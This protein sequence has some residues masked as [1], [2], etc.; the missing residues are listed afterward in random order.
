MFTLV[1]KKSARNHIFARMRFRPEISGPQLFIHKQTRMKRAN[2]NNNS[3][4]RQR[5]TKGFA[6]KSAPVYI[7]AP[8]LPSGEMKYFDTYKTTTALGVVTTTWPAGA[9]VD[10]TTTV[11]LGAAAVATPLSLFVPTVGSALN[12]R[13]GR[14]VLVRKIKIHG[15]ITAAATGTN[16]AAYEP[17]LPQKVRLMLVQ[18]T[19]TNAAQMTAA[20]L[21]DD[22][23]AAEH[24]H[25]FI[26]EPQ[27]LWQVQGAQG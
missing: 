27:Q 20:Q 11:N 1:S 7:M 8:K 5:K 26:P 25:Q 23:G 14:S 22:G 6:G 17:Y 19:Q 16:L 21:A 13:I 18:D 24:H 9:M 15:Q 12:Q 4:K 2:Q 3:A 10:P